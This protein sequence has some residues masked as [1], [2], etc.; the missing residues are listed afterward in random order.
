M[1]F[2]ILGGRKVEFDPRRG[3]STVYRERSWIGTVLR[4]AI[5]GA[6]IATGMTVAA[7][8]PAYAAS[9]IISTKSVPAPL[10]FNGVCSRYAW[11]CSGSSQSRV[12]GAEAT[13][14]L[15]RRINNSVNARV[16]EVSDLRQYRREEY[17]SLPTALGGDCEDFALLKK[18]ELIKAGVAPNQLLVA[19]VLDRR[20][21]AHAVLVVRTRA[22]D[23]VLDN[24][25]NRIKP[26]DKTGYSFIRI[27]DPRAPSRWTLVLKGGLFG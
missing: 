10:G 19:T 2:G 13:L 24:L 18:R 20:R 1:G 12:S 23:F 15:A 27:Q 22:G 3:N 8:G 11:A 4:A 7:A 16:R 14:Q 9:A 26:W 5:T 6:V 17:W 25:T 21:N